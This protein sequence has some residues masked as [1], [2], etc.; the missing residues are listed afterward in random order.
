MGKFI[1]TE[2]YTY[3]NDDYF[4]K[5]ELYY[6]YTTYDVEYI[7]VCIGKKENGIHLIKIYSETPK[8]KDEEIIPEDE[9]VMNKSKFSSFKTCEKITLDKATDKSGHVYAFSF[10]VPEQKDG[11]KAND[12]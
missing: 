1:R 5:G 10:K 8:T 6:I 2:T 7:A 11:Q 4:E 12:E 3:L 9:I